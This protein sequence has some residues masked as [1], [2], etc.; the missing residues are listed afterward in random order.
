MFNKL[1]T[2]LLVCC[3]EETNGRIFVST[4]NMHHQQPFV[5][6]QLHEGLGAL[7]ASTSHG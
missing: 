5:C 4:V 7:L 6:P 1:L 2:V 3:K